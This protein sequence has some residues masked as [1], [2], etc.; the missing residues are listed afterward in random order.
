MG[1]RRIG[2]KYTFWRPI[3]QYRASNDWKSTKVL[4]MVRRGL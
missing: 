4:K 3:L 1:K 2:D